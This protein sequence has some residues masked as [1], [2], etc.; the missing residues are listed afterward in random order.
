LGGPPQ[1]PG[2]QSTAPQGT[3]LADTLQNPLGAP[4]TDTNSNAQNF[5]GSGTF[6]PMGIGGTNGGG[7]PTQMQPITAQNNFMGFNMGGQTLGQSN[8]AT[9][10]QLMFNPMNA[11]PQMSLPVDNPLQSVGGAGGPPQA[12]P[13]LMPAPQQPPP[14]PTGPVAPSAKR[15]MAPA[16]GT[17]VSNRAT[18]PVR[19]QPMRTTAKPV[20]MR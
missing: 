17:A 9:G 11:L 15:P 10:Q 1:D 20:R 7:E 6:N 14:Q 18:G 12:Q 3:T 2:Q 13:T 8:L 16:R 5:F 19:P 4:Q